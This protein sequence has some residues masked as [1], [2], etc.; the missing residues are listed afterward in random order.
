MRS[1]L[2]P[3]SSLRR[4][5][6]SASLQTQGSCSNQVGATLR[7]CVLVDGRHFLPQTLLSR[8]MLDKIGQDSLDK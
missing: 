7:S 5:S 3:A 1:G 8:S 4:L 6:R 2:V